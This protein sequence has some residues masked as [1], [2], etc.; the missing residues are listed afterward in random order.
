MVSLS[1]VLL[2]YRVTCLWLCNKRYCNKKGVLFVLDPVYLQFFCKSKTFLKWKVYFWKL[3]TEKHPFC[4]PR[5]RQ[6]RVSF[7]TQSGFDPRSAV[8]DTK[9][10]ALHGDSPPCRKEKTRVWGWEW[11]QA[12]CHIFSRPCDPRLLVQAT[13]CMIPFIWNSQNRQSHR[14]RK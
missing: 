1:V 11:E 10:L 14:D 9:A 3:T 7:K 12:V 13:E 2:C 6:H 5:R 8:P 4:F